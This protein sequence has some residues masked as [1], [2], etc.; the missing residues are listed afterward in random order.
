MSEANFA[1]GMGPADGCWATIADAEFDSAQISKLRVGGPLDDHNFANRGDIELYYTLD[2]DRIVVQM[3]PFTFAPNEASAFEDVDRLIPW[4]YTA[5]SVAPP[6][7]LGADQACVIEGEWQDGCSVRVWYDGLAQKLR[8]GADLRVFVPRGWEGEVELATEDNIVEAE[9]PSRG[10]IRVVDLPGSGDVTLDGGSA[11]VR[12]DRAT[13]PV[14]AC[15]AEQN[16]ACAEQGWDQSAE[17]CLPC[18]DFGRIHVESRGGTAA[19]ITVDAPPDLW[20]SAALENQQEGLT[21]GSDPSCFISIDCEGFGGC[22]WTQNDPLMPW[23]GRALLNQPAQA[24]LGLGYNVRLSS[25]A[26]Q[27]SMEAEGPADYGAPRPSWH[28]S[29]ELCS[30]CLEELEAPEP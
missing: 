7:Q 18:V 9:Y 28:G 19:N 3:R 14:P 20:I 12:L 24:L 2:S 13:E 21:P 17:A 22:E 11:E 25:A 16:A 26:C 23:K 6:A 8:S 29:L 1:G 10:H 30:G 27:E 5:S 4:L 15:S